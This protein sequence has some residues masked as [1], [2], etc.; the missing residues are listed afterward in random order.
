MKKTTFFFPLV[1]ASAVLLSSCFSLFGGVLNI[2]LTFK[3]NLSELPV[4]E[5]A[6]ITFENFS[7]SAVTLF[8]KKESSLVFWLKR[9]N[10]IDINEALYRNLSSDKNDKAELIVPPG[11]NS[12]IFDLFFYFE[13]STSTFGSYEMQNIEL[14]YNLAAGHKYIVKARADTTTTRTRRDGELPLLSIRH[15]I[16]IGIYTDVKNSGPLR[17]WKLEVR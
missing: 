1:L 15:E 12:F 5:S 10:N 9:W 4:N 13:D 17:E 3:D 6:V 8:S 11:D 16:I 14:Q 7:E 2:S